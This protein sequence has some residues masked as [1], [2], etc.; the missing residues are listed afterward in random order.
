MRARVVNVVPEEVVLGVRWTRVIGSLFVAMDWN[1][2]SR[3]DP[4]EPACDPSA[5]SGLVAV[6]G[7]CGF[8][9]LVPDMLRDRL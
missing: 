8:A 9:L 6:L 1:A 4:G 3:M 7:M 2:V 5:D